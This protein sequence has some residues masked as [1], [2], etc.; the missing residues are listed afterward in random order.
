MPKAV[1]G[2]EG[3]VACKKRLKSN[4]LDSTL[5]VLQTWVVKPLSRGEGKPASGSYNP[6][7]DSPNVWPSCVR[8]RL[9]LRR[10]CHISAGPVATC[11]IDQ[12]QLTGAD[13]C[14]GMHRLD[15]PCVLRMHLRHC[16][17]GAICA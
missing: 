10:M 17:V 3:V 7:Y 11:P 1:H 9:S 14:G 8:L 15:N 4:C 16:I 13:P 2:C 5:P 6:P 12:T